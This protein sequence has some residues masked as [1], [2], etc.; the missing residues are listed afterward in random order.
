M[1]KTIIQTIGPLYGEV[2]NGTV[3][4]RPNGSVYVPPTNTV[5][6]DIEDANK[7]VTYVTTQAGNHFIR[8][9]TSAGAVRN[10]GFVAESQDL[11]S[12]LE[13]SLYDSDDV[14]IGTSVQY[15]AGLFNLQRITNVVSLAED[16][17]PLTNGDTY[18]IKV[19]LYAS[20]GVPVAVSTVSVDGV[21]S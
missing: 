10:F 19:T 13:T 21:V 2:V 5:S 17:N 9:C 15:T 8:I 14:E 7:Y 18:T 12:Y 4:G 6:I 20:T 1:G 16:V 3:F 11:N